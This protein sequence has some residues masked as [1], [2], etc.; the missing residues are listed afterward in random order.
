MAGIGFVLRKLLKKK[1]LSSFSSVCLHAMMASCGPWLITVLYFVGAYEFKSALLLNFSIAMILTSSLVIIMTRYLADLVYE[2]KIKNSVGMLFGSSFLFL[3]L[4]TPLVFCVTPFRLALNILTVSGIWICSPFISALKNYWGVTLSFIIGGVFAL[5]LD[6]DLCPLFT[7]AALIFF[8][9]QEFP[10][11]IHAP[12]HF[13]TYFRKY[14]E[15]A[16]SGLFFALG[17]WSDKWIMWYFGIQNYDTA[18]L[19]AYLTSIP[20]M[21]LFIV[22][23]ETKFHEVYRQ[24]FSGIL[25][26]ANLDQINSNFENIKKCLREVAKKMISL[27]IIVC[28]PAFLLGASTTFRLGILCASFQVLTIFMTIVLTYFDCRRQVLKIQVLFFISN[29]LFTF[30]FMNLPGAGY[31]ISS[32]LTFL[33]TALTAYRYIQKIPYYSFC[34][35]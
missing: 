14:W 22:S 17:I 31:L 13:L 23:E 26:H 18:I 4:V 33:Y 1:S 16:L 12:F 25:N 32:L 11:E 34:P 21:A 7:L 28:L 3:F 10:R 24:Y 6:N 27:Q 5:F 35:N 2:E 30:L 19:A 15:L 29:A 9:L 20:A 8:I